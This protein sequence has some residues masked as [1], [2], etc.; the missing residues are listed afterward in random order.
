MIESKTGNKCLHSQSCPTEASLSRGLWRVHCS[1]LN[2]LK[3]SVE[4]KWLQTQ[5]L[6]ERNVQRQALSCCRKATDWL[7][8]LHVWIEGKPLTGLSNRIIVKPLEGK[9]KPHQL[10]LDSCFL[11]WSSNSLPT[12]ILRPSLTSKVSSFL[13]WEAEYR[14][15]SAEPLSTTD[16]CPEESG[17][18]CFP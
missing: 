4:G 18:C 6:C 14:F 1:A 12:V 11:P 10:P 5:G 9:K 3:W 8:V 7:W 15:R 13:F 2:R 17:A 16:S